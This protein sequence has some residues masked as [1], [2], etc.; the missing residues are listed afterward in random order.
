MKKPYSIGLDIG[1]NSVGFSAIDDNYQVI[2]KK[3]R[4]MGNTSRQYDNKLIL[5]ALLFSEGDTA[6]ERRVS[7]TTRRRYNRRRQ[8]LLYLQE[9]FQDEMN[10]VDENFFH[11]LD[12]S[13]LQEEDKLF[14]KYTIF[15]ISEEEKNY[16]NNYPTIYH[17]RRDLADK[18]EKGDL[19]LVYLALAHILKS[20]GHFL[21]E[22]NID[23]D[24]IGVREK[25][26]EFLGEYNSVFGQEIIVNSHDIEEILTGF[27][28][29]SRKVEAIID[30]IP[31]E[32]STGNMAQFL[33]LIVGNQGEFKKVYGLEEKAPLSFTKE[34]YE[35]DLDKLLLL[36]NDETQQLLFDSA[37]A[38]YDAVVL[39]GILTVK[40]K[41][42]KVPFSSSMVQRYCEHKKD[43]KDFKL[44]FRNYL[45]NQYD[46]M[47]KDKSVKGYAGYIEG[48]HKKD[49][50]GKFIPTS[51]P[52]SQEEFYKFTRNLIGKIPEA[53]VFLDKIDKEVF[54]L[55]QRS[56][57]NGVIPHQVQLNELRAIIKR[58][59]KFY[60]FLLKNL[61]KIESILTFRIPYYVGP[62]ARGNSDFAWIER[63]SDDKIRPWN[64]EQ[65]VDLSAS[66]TAFIERMT[67]ND[68]YLPNKK[69]LPRHSL[70]Y[71]EFSIF[72]E[73]TRVRYTA[74]G[75]SEYEFLTKKQKADIFNIFKQRRT[76]SE[77]N[78][79]NYLT[80]EDGLE[81][82]E[83]KGIEKRFNATYSTYHDLEKIFGKEFLDDI[84]N[85][86][87]I[88]KII[89]TLTIFEDRK[90]IEKKLLSCCD[91]LTKNQIS[92]LA[93]KKYTGW[94]R[95]S[96]DLI[97]GIKD[98][99]S[100]KTILDFLKDDGFSNRNFMQLIND[101]SLDFKDIIKKSQVIKDVSNNRTIV[102]N[103]PGSP[104]LKKGILQSLNIVD[105]I[106]KVMG[107][108]PSQIVIEMARENQTSQFGRNQSRQRL[109]QIEEGLEQLES[110][111]LI[112]KPIKDNKLLQ[113][114]KLF[115]Y[116]LQDGKDMYTGKPLDSDP[117]S[118][119]T[120]D[121][122]HIV[123]RSFLKDNSIDNK[124]L[125]SS[126]E[127]RKK[128]DDVP[129]QEV[130]NKQYVWWA[131]LKKAG[132]IS[133]KK[134][135]YLTKGELTERDKAGFIN[136]QLVE[137]RQI[138]KHV[139]HILDEK[140]NVN[141]RGEHTRSVE[142]IM[143]KSIFANRFRN[144]FNLRKI[145]GLNDFHHAHDAYL[146]AVVA[147]ALLT[148]YPKLKKEL[149]YG[150]YYHESIFDKKR[151]SATDRLQMYNNILKFFVKDYKISNETDEILW[152]K[153]EVVKVVE[154][155]IYHQPVTIVRKT[156]TNHGALFKA[157]NK[158][159]GYNNNLIPRKTKKVY[160]DVTK[161]GGFI[162]PSEAYTVA[163]LTIG[164]KGKFK[165]KPQWLLRGISQLEQKDFEKNQLDFLKKN[166]F[167]T[168][169]KVIRLPKY[170]L[171]EFPNGRRRYLV[172]SGE[173][174]K[175]N[176]ITLP[177]HLI[178]LLYQLQHY[179]D[180]VNDKARNY[181]IEE[182]IDDF[183]ELIRIFEH[184]NTEFIQ[185]DSNFI[186]IKSAFEKNKQ[187]DAK[188]LS[189]SFINLL[190][191]VQMRASSEF[192]FLGTKIGRKRYSSPNEI[193]S[194]T[195]V[196]QSITGL[197]ETRID[198]SKLGE[199]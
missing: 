136:R 149:A 111:L 32:K 5:G 138:T 132:L 150:D 192:D 155:V 129:S 17:L 113:K 35:E 61:D 125:T 75:M 179:G 157:S 34:T 116:Y 169:K 185:A 128:L 2:N 109:K 190:N 42:T 51:K 13:F 118:L 38:V 19:R 196:Y 39:S 158:A 139:A 16:H 178:E 151:F 131:K 70:I 65:L 40:D 159:V 54:L 140:F 108:K 189:E 24:N 6:E 41:S 186:K 146:N 164:T 88:E 184:Y 43:L 83:L 7:R 148:V 134:F 191:F 102:K 135:S 166:G 104:K 8:R 12:E 94:G 114:E 152:K 22:G 25:F 1:T 173:L 194:S 62:L 127:N 67:V 44:F 10:Q 53:Q 26:E 91:A 181:N 193:L 66:A 117:E 21:Q 121:V 69:V 122:D 171:F 90:M 18:D 50:N 98:K 85:R 160:L 45:P 57:E 60:P 182:H 31:T 145:R 96:Y 79:K 23:L 56:F 133:D 47:F 101:D 110:N 175:G 58:Q 11:R 80:K 183:G 187:K 154:N 36:V 29:K 176:Q 106:V 14:S 77:K 63:K 126:K 97:D 199:E 103:I 68:T 71:Q 46:N 105:E 107:Y 30:L 73:L 124:V 195:L 168:I 33:K 76:V 167:T 9:I 119:A 156:E 198:L 4:V 177:Q 64:F 37:K 100:H 123:P 197:Y 120:Y 99:Q 172:S 93:R 20:R 15:G 72:N 142:I 89:H 130:V 55:K 84:D 153:E 163:I 28:S 48:L 180:V 188:T 144:E 170:S 81:G 86:N 92:E 87:T 137:T 174:Q 59:G 161:Y 82:V 3:M 141:E 49:K 95:F 112:E 115:L 78:V 52:V 143:L 162:E 27:A 147:K 165:N 74:E